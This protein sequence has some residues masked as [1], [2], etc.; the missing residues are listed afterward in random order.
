MTVMISIAGPGRM[1]PRGAGFLIFLCVGLPGRPAFSQTV[2][3]RLGSTHVAGRYYFTTDN[4]LH[5]GATQILRTG[6]R[7]I[8]VYLSPGG[9][10][11]NSTWPPSFSSNVAMAQHPYYQAL[12]AMPFKTFVMTCYSTVDANGNYW[13]FGVN[14]TQLA[15]ERQQFYELAKHFLITY[16]GT[17][18]TFVLSHWEGDWSLRGTTDQSPAFDP[19]QYR[20]QYMAAWLNAR[21]DGV[22]QARA[23]VADTDVKVYHAPEMN[24]LDLAMQGRPTVTNNVLPSTH[25]DLVSCSAWD[26][27]SGANA[28]HI[29][30]ALN[31][32]ASKMPDRPPYGNG[33]VYIGEFGWPE[34]SAGTSWS[35]TVIKTGTQAALNWGC[36]WV[37]Y[38]QIYDN[39]CD[40][41]PQ[42]N[43]DCRGFWMIRRDGSLA[44]SYDFFVSL[45]NTMPL[46]ENLTRSPVVSVVTDSTH[47]AAE[48]GAKAIDG[49][50]AAN[51]KWTSAGSAPPHWLALDLG[52]IRQ[53]HTFVV[54]HAGAGGETGNYNTRLFSIQSAASMSGPWTDEFA[55]D[56]SSSGTRYNLSLRSY[57]T[58]KPLRYV[59]LHITNAGIDNYARIP[60]FE[61]WGDPGRAAFSVSPP[62]GNC[63]LGVQFT[64]TSGNVDAWSWDFGDGATSTQP[65][66]AHTY[67]RPGLFTVTLTVTSPGGVQS[68]TTRTVRAR[69]V[70]FDGDGDVDQSDYS[71]LQRCFSADGLTQAAP[72]CA[73]AL[74]DTDDDV[75]VTDLALFLACLNGADRPPAGGCAFS[76]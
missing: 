71:L 73:P 45:M 76:P 32:L 8:K 41:D 17:G 28:T 72:S 22:D 53:V 74:I 19:P 59:R 9:Y 60:E 26:I 65:N 39:E 64:D 62:A 75:D 23:E 30:N 13:W 5:E 27:V 18:K 43:S 50:V 15:A 36:P 68:Q 52:R 51:S 33:N 56:N 48:V 29:N 24:L 14:Q 31:Y 47:S 20:C 7:T 10:P 44:P 34:I 69:G 57:F 42:S 38:W 54:R 25:C 70:D 67:T 2:A 35:T 46:G 63:P 37:I 3:D 12:F 11:Y 16:R 66:P 61:V 1:L 21:Q 58:S 49:V 4:Y 6:M 55:V 40:A